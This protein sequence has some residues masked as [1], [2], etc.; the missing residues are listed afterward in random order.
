MKKKLIEVA[1]PLE[2]INRESAREKSIRHGHPSTL[3][4][5]WARR[6]LATCRAVLFASLVDDPS[7]LPEQ[8]PT[9]V[10]QDIERQRLFRILE[11]LVLWEN[12]NNPAV[13]DRAKAEIL[14]S[15]DGHPPPVYDPFCGGGSIPLEAQRLGLEAYGS[16]LNPV[17]VLITKALIEIPPK[18]A[19]Q[20][21]INPLAKARFSGEGMWIGAVGLAD[22]VR[23][24]GQW[25]RDRAVE[26]IEHLYPK[27]KLENGEEA[28]VIAWLWARTIECP[29]P[30][31]LARMPIVR[32]FVL[33][34]KK[35]REIWAEPIIEHAGK[36]VRFELR[37]GLGPVPE[38]T[39]QR[40][41]ARCLFCG[42]VINDSVVR[43]QATRGGFGEILI[44]V[45]AEGKGGR[46][47]LQAD[48][49]PLPTVVVPS[50][51][52]LDQ[53]LC[54]NPRWFSPPGYGLKDFADL[55]TP[56]QLVALV[57][58]SNLI[59]DA[60]KKALS[61]GAS[62]EYAD[63][64]ALYLAFCFDKC[65]DYW[66]TISSWSQSGEFIRNCFARQAIPMTWD[67]AE[68]NPFSGSTANWSGP[69]EWV[70]KVLEELPGGPQGF[71]SLRDATTLEKQAMISTDP[72]YYDNIGY[73]DLSDFFYVWLRRNIGSRY[74]DLMSTL[75][76]PKRQELIATPYRFEGSKQ[77]AQK[78]F[79]DGFRA[80]FRRMRIVHSSEHPLTVYYAFKQSES[81]E[82]E[83]VSVQEASTG[84]ETMLEGLLQSG[85]LVTATWPMRSERP[86][87]SISIGTNALAS[88]I[89]LVCRPRS[90][91]APITTRKDFLSQM[92]KELPGALRNLQ[93]GNVAPVD[94]A[95]AAIGPG[96]GVFSRYARVLEANGES[97]S[98]RAALGLINQTLDEVLSEQES[99][100]DPET[101]WALQ[102]FEQYQF[103]EAPFGQAE[104]LASAKAVSIHGLQEAG[105]LLA[106]AGK[107]RLIPRA[108]LDPTWDPTTDG[109]LTIWEVTQHLIRVLETRGEPEAAEL[110][111]KLGGAAEAAREL[112]YRLYALC[113][114]KGWA[115]EA[116][117]Y[118]NLVVRWPDLR[119]DEFSLS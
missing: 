40:N 119:S 83:G 108:E 89:V 100:F 59:T 102:W 35:S 19:G 84:W 46:V 10:E 80:A 27:P 70:A 113:E 96:M 17:A 8:F 11:E 118:N 32:S 52:W 93:K 41:R 4:L 12:S 51:P 23:H 109:R 75:L 91:S 2:A 101:R 14:R 72:P 107:V 36:T 87:R 94:M 88:S 81:D 50:T 66:N 55:F 116:G 97:M 74:N 39:K 28:V 54:S 47:Y 111:A 117:A 53:A 15:T 114:R 98:V 20:P 92:K 82:Q 73:A 29:N 110:K 3:H 9:E 69:I 33:S 21:P 49:C 77:R 67:F 58:F 103:N 105:I 68:C 99:D 106:R 85:F 25:M 13:L 37:S 76:V 24:Y 79:E 42:N 61:D 34:T 63:A 78:F 7:S 64:I 71:V 62:V 31:C 86:G 104:T 45:V 30:A 1:L 112:A 16:D 56:R 115:Q 95:Q 5:W 57:T 43:E 48:A 38:G 65:C 22:D 18:F 44:A 90:D 6:P 26:R 60:R